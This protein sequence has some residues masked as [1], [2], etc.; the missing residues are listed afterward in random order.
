LALALGK[1]NHHKAMFKAFIRWK[2]E[3]KTFEQE[4]LAE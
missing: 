2:R 1:N 3:T 4:R